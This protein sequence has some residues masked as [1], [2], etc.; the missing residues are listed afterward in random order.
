MVMPK[1]RAPA[2]SLNASAS[3][4]RCGHRATTHW[5]YISPMHHHGP[6]TTTGSNARSPET[7][8]VTATAETSA[9][10]E[11]AARSARAAADYQA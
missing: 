2:P 11:T 7:T 8:A 10:A 1:C 9:T 6:R 3:H 4:R 5:A